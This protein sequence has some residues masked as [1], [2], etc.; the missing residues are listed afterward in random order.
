MIDWAT[1]R[2]GEPWDFTRK[3]HIDTAEGWVITSIGT[4]FTPDG[5]K[6]TVGNRAPWFPIGLRERTVD[7]KKFRR[8]Q[9]RVRASREGRITLRTHSPGYESHVRIAL[10]PGI[11][12]TTKWQ[13]FDLDLRKARGGRWGGPEGAIDRIYFQLDFPLDEGV[14]VEISKIRLLGT[15]KADR[16]PPVITPLPDRKGAVRFR[17]TDP[18]GVLA[19]SL[20]MIVNDVVYTPRTKA[21]KWDG[22]VLSWKGRYHDNRDLVVSVEASDREGNRASLELE[23][24]HVLPTSG[25][26]PAPLRAG[27]PSGRRS[28]AAAVK[29]GKGRRRIRVG[30]RHEPINR[31]IEIRGPVTDPKILIDGN[32]DF[33]TPE[34]IVSSILD[35]RMSVEEKAKRIWQ[36]VMENVYV[37]GMGNPVDR[38]KY[39]NS[40]GYG[41]CG[42][43][44]PVQMALY[45]AAGVPWMHL[46]YVWPKGHLSV[47]VF[48]DGRWH[49][50]DS[51]NRGWVLTDNGRTIASAEEIE[52]D[53]DIIGPTE[54][55]MTPV[56]RE[57]LRWP[58][59]R[60]RFESKGD[61][62]RGGSM[63]MRLRKNE[64][65]RLTWSPLGKWCH[66]PSEP[67][68]YVNGRLTFRPFA[69]TGQWKQDAESVSN[70]EYSRE[71][72][73]V[74]PKRTGRPAHITYRMHSPYLMAGGFVKLGH[75]RNGARNTI[76]VSVS[77]DGGARW[78]EI[79]KA[80]GNGD[81]ESQIDL[82][83][84]MSRRAVEED[85]P[86]FRDVHEFLL[87]VEMI[88]RGRRAP[89]VR[90]LT[91]VPILQVHGPSLQRLRRGDNTCR[92]R[93][94]LTPQGRV[95]IDH[96]WDETG[97]V[98]TSSERPARGETVVLSAA[99]RNDEAVPL[100]PLTVRFYDGS[101][102]AD[103]VPIGK[104][105]RVRSVPAGRSVTVKTK[106]R[107]EPRAHRP[108]GEEAR[109][110]LH[111]DVYAAVDLPRNR[112]PAAGYASTGR[113]RLH[114]TD[115]PRMNLPA[116]AIRVE[117][118]KPKPGKT[119][120][121]SAIIWNVSAQ[122]N[123]AEPPEY[124]YWN[125][126]ELKDVL[127]RFYHGSPRK[128][129][130]PIGRKTIR[131]IPPCEHGTARIRWRI[132]GNAK[133][134][135]IYVVASHQTGPS[136]AHQRKTVRRRVVLPR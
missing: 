81:G 23:R 93:G 131:R 60:Y 92:Y 30:G 85:R 5:L 104:P 26:R 133:K 2:L 42:S 1:S 43:Q 57:N 70:V 111:T 83:R 61:E 117:P 105:V 88:R 78:E 20:A 64:S 63:G 122:K 11:R 75:A 125:G 71:E 69:G 46:V 120:T 37:M 3:E 38:T 7:A 12:V 10:D 76:A 54:G 129:G 96:D 25:K 79:W 35:D 62:L 97:A 53:P 124:V 101:P 27:F 48:Y 15:G 39:L 41:F 59:M 135:D 130:R 6:V 44:A 128:G 72:G 115:K 84:W 114:V 90:D 94:V 55:A 106:W 118:G 134:L 14:V 8:M 102:D 47:Q 19:S 73:C 50:I 49:I 108:L 87:R 126:A 22:K 56:Y 52:G 112:V 110:Y 51:M 119:V 28:C 95:E 45:E 34:T 86:L 33:E 66:A 99:V 65:L 29:G 74:R 21:L 100:G 32:I 4:R 16:E 82:T 123:L 68:D 77:T 31:S 103:G 109:R 36:F 24:T 136:S 13:T 58:K 17:I 89:E 91:I 113:V 18:A 127:V 67:V 116:N 80:G 9:I 107:A 121:L 40:C 98:R 132:P